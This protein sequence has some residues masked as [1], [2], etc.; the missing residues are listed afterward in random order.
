MATERNP[1]DLAQ[2]AVN[3]TYIRGVLAATVEDYASWVVAEESDLDP[4]ACERWVNNVWNNLR[5]A[6]DDE[7]RLRAILLLL[8]D[9]ANQ[10]ARVLMASGEELK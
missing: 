1:E 8:T 4:D 6:L 9:R 3:E 7:Q 10:R 2:D 5:A